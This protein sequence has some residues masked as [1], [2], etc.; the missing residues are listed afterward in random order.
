MY[1]NILHSG[2]ESKV[3]IHE[4]LFFVLQSMELL[5]IAVILHT[6]NIV[7]ADLCS[8]DANMHNYIP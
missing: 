6:D 8:N 5:G 4:R 7:R 2:M 1:L 3:V